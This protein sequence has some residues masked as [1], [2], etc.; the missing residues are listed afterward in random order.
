ME[1]AK[2]DKFLRDGVDDLAKVYWKSNLNKLDGYK[3]GLALEQ[4]ASSRGIYKLRELLGTPS[5]TISSQ[6]YS[7]MSLKVQRS[8]H[9]NQN[10]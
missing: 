9:T 5:W 3:T 10:G 7:G 4:D 1:L 6:A 2:I 8:K